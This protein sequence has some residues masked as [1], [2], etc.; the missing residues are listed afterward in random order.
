MYLSEIGVRGF[1]ASATSEIRCRFP[2]RFSVIVG[3]NSAGK[4]TVCDGLSLSHAHVF[5]QI[6]RPNAASLGPT[7]REV[8]VAFAFEADGQEGPAGELLQK[9]AMPAPSWTRQLER[10]MGR[11]SARSLMM[12]ESFDAIE[13]PRMIYLPAMRNPVDE[14][15]RREARI[16][17]ELLRA[18][19]QARSGHRNLADVRALASRLLETLVA[20]DLLSSVETRV[21]SH[22]HALTSGVSKQFP[23]I[24]GQHV[25]DTYLA[26]VIE[27]MLSSVDTRLDATRLELSGLGYVNLLHIA[28]TLAAIPDSTRQTIADDDPLNDSVL[29]DAERIKQAEAEAESA[30]DSFFPDAFHVT[31]VIEEPEAHLHPQL[32]TGLVRY[33]Q[34]TVKSR[35]EVQVI[36]TTHSGTIISCCEPE[37][38][39]VLRRTDTGVLCRDIASIPLAAK[40]KTRTLQMAKLHMDATRSASLFGEREVLVEGITDAILVRQLGRA[41]ALNDDDKLRFIDALTITP[42]GT[43]VGRWP[44]DLLA[45]QGFEIVNKLAVLRDS[46]D[47]INETPGLPSWIAEFDPEH[48]RCFISHPTLEPILV[49]GNES[50]V[51]DVL[52]TMGIAHDQPVGPSMIDELFQDKSKRKAEFALELAGAIEAIPR[53]NRST[54]VVPDHFRSMFEFLY[55]REELSTEDSNPEPATDA[56]SA[57]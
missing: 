38:L 25:D 12:N 28:V 35:P 52:A 21:R 19:Q 54:V 17:V 40:L 49:T 47:R 10:N 9:A 7:P 3:A 44:V 51:A 48:V 50:I 15:A 23:F 55:D 56:P 27:F 31:V 41:W 6:N 11:V 34:D 42:V 29:D 18:E 33:L 39:V 14:L 24:G 53:S 26:R 5:P 13:A 1:R 2:G 57:D 30:E 43:K 4:T 8:E 37:E 36:L 46:D 16:L 20:H 45:T 22:L 32:Q